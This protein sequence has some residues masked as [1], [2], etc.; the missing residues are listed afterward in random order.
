MNDSKIM[1]EHKVFEANGHLTKD[2]AKEQWARI[3]D[4]D[5]KVELLGVDY[6]KQT[7][8]KNTNLWLWK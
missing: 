7:Y 8:T 5:N 6:S 2:I 1:K 3:G 4:W